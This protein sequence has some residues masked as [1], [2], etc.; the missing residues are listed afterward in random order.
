MSTGPSLKR[1]AVSGSA[2]IIAGFGM[3]QALRLAGNLILT[4]LLFP[5][6]FGI[7]ALV[8]MVMRG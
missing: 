8:E 4:R 5:E 6:A 1:L 7:M 2:W 3:S